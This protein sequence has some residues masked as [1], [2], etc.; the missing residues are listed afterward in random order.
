MTAPD[1]YR[2]DVRRHV[3]DIR[4]HSGTDCVQCNPH[5]LS[6]LTLKY[7]NQFY[8]RLAAL[9]RNK[10]PPHQTNMFNVTFPD[11]RVAE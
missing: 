1:V 6:L 4:R 7:Q 2:E 5:R 10:Y 3:Q 9:L 11:S 8:I